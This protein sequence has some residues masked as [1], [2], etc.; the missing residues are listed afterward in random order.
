[1]NKRRI[2]TITII[3]GGIL[4]WGRVTQAGFGISPP[5][6]KSS[7][8]IFAGAHYEQKITLL[9]SAAD[10]DL[11]A[12]ITINAPEID[13]WVSIEQGEV[14]DLPKGKLQVPMIVRVDVPSDAEIGNYKGY[15]NVRVSPKDEDSGAGVAIALGAR[16]DIDLDVTD[17]VFV[18]FLLRNVKIEDIETLPFPW[19]LPIF[20]HFFYKTKVVLDVENTGN[21]K[22]APTKVV[23]EVYDLAEKELL[24]S[25]T[26]DSIA[27]V[28][29]F[30]RQKVYADFRTKLKPGQYWGKVKVYRDNDIIKNDKITFNVF[31][32]G[33]GKVNT[34]LGIMP[35]IMLSSIV[36]I[37][38]LIIFALI[39]F[40]S[41]RLVFKVLFILTYP[42]RVLFGKTKGGFRGLK[43]KFWKWVHKKA[44]KYQDFDR[45]K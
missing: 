45:K 40:R 36:L 41:W 42:V 16:V 5:Y 37:F 38:V 35:W 31:E 19:R 14:F 28:D 25:Y 13:S 32:N 34:D 8:P 26:D 12:K 29:P 27:K 10:D 20:S 3:L 24:E 21:V 7:K 4:A 9:R 33:Q 11:Q 6:V 1:M 18:D 15:I 17:E 23:M 30:D 22:T 43:V 2:I 39:K 44:S